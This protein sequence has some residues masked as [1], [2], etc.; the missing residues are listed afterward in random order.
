MWPVSVSVTGNSSPSSRRESQQEMHTSTLTA[1]TAPV[2]SHPI[3]PTNTHTSSFLPWLFLLP[4]D[5]LKNSALFPETSG[6][7]SSVNPSLVTPR[8]V[9]NLLPRPLSTLRLCLS[10]K[11]TRAWKTWADISIRQLIAWFIP[12]LYIKP[13]RL[14]THRIFL[15]EKAEGLV[16]RPVS[17]YFRRGDSPLNSFSNQLPDEDLQMFL[18]SWEYKEKSLQWGNEANTETETLCCLKSCFL[19]NLDLEQMFAK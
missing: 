5:H 18:A 6:D 11:G 8:R 15:P 1:L 19:R 12:F 4:L 16:M 13:D 2:I 17:Q 10:E 3:H 7:A 14:G 9:Q